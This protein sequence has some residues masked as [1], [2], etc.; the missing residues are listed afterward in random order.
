V[1]DPGTGTAAVDGSNYYDLTVRYQQPT[2]LL[3][4]PGPNIDVTRSKRVWI[5]GAAS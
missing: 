2:S 5:A 3:L 1:S 4:F